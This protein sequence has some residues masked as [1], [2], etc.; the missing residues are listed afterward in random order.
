MHNYVVLAQQSFEG[1]DCEGILLGQAN[2]DLLHIFS[3]FWGSYEEGS[4]ASHLIKA[5][6]MPEKF[7]ISR[8]Q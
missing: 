2:G 7:S 5:S 8:E 6:L 1:W 4:T 3:A